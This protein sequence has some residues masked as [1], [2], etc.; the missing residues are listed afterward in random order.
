MS[1]GIEWTAEVVEKLRTFWN[2]GHPVNEIG[3][4]LGVSKNAVIGK[5][6]RLGLTGRNSPII[7][8]GQPRAP[9]IPPSGR[10]TLPAFASAAPELFVT[11]TIIAPKKAARE[12]GQPLNL[13]PETE[14]QIKLLHANGLGYKAICKKTK[15]S[16]HVVRYTL[17]YRK[18]RR[19]WQPKAV[20]VEASVTL[21]RKPAFTAP[22]R[23]AEVA[24]LFRPNAGQC[25]WLEG[26]KPYVQCDEPAL[27]GEGVAR[28]WS[29]C[30]CHRAKAYA[31]RV[32]VRD[33]GV[34]A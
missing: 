30:Q 34:A 2:Q 9:R 19:E 22:E 3:R 13:D 8:N 32:F 17:G 26:L 4:R 12:W 29:F 5:S 23:P 1:I 18:P 11:T 27:A 10:I 6:H 20:E 21:A 15:V 14:A 33:A 16:D 31:G 7:R 28:P 24:P 25:Q